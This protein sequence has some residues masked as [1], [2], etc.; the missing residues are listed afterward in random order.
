M[1]HEL[2]PSLS[3]KDG[4]IVTTSLAVAAH[5]GK[6]HKDVLKAIY[7]LECSEEFRQ[8]NFAP[9][10]YLNSQ[11]KSQ[12]YFEMTRDGFTFLAMGFTGKEAA[13][14]KEA[15]VNAFNKMEAELLH[16]SQLEVRRSQGLALEYAKLIR[17]WLPNL[18]DNSLQQILSDVCLLDLGTRLIPLPVLSQKH[19][20][21]TELAQEL[22]VSAQKIGRVANAHRLKTEEFGEFR[23]SKS[24]HSSKQVE[25]FFYNEKGRA[26]LLLAFNTDD[27]VSN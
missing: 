3:I 12:P 15:Y 2:V 7:N 24:Q 1:S 8:R 18:G 14:W 23:L 10:E 11:G 27:G 25:Q 21:A 19:Y 4:K 9:S 13:K 20:T 22:G 6:Q 5:F 26:A 16:C 17:E